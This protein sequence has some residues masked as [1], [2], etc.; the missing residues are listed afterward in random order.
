MWA[1][2][3]CIGVP[4]VLGRSL[5]LRPAASALSHQFSSHF[6]SQLHL[7][8]SG[9]LCNCSPHTFRLHSLCC[10]WSNFSCG[11]KLANVH[12]Q[13]KKS[14]LFIIYFWTKNCI[15]RTTNISFFAFC[16]S[17]GSEMEVNMLFL[18]QLCPGTTEMKARENPQSCMY[19][20]TVNRATKK[21]REEAESSPLTCWAVI[22]A[23]PLGK[24]CLVGIFITVF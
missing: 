13:P 8:Q 10:M 7:L 5:V 18:L 17:S 6:L 4:L 15:S 19:T 20:Y 21:K 2:G 24:Y 23:V 12:H 16:I 1:V 9:Y 22:R 14:C 11:V 3:P